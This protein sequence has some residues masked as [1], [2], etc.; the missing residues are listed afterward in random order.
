MKGFDVSD[1]TNSKGGVNS[2]CLREKKQ[3]WLIRSEI[4]W[5]TKK[6]WCSKT[7]S[8][9]ITRPIFVVQTI[10][11]HF[12]WGSFRWGIQKWNKILQF[13][14]EYSWCLRIC[15][16]TAIIFFMFQNWLMLKKNTTWVMLANVS[17][18]CHYIFYV[19]K[20]ALSLS[21]SL[22]I[23][24]IDFIFLFTSQQLFKL[25]FNVVERLGFEEK[26]LGLKRLGLK[27]W[28]LKRLGLKRLGLKRLSLV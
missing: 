20:L 21:L 6:F 9:T 10:I 18:N 2:W 1:A 15:H 3:V 19:S 11:D 12:F 22:S 17:Q 8:K 16:K 25:S 23:C 14:K 5:K 27:R 7:C 28:G 4:E 26:R 24:F 13:I